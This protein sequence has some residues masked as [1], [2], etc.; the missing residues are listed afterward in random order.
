MSNIFSAKYVP[1]TANAIFTTTDVAGRTIEHS[2]GLIMTLGENVGVTST[3]LAQL[4]EA[5]LAKATE[6]GANAIIGARFESALGSMSL[7]GT[8][9]RL[10][11]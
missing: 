9:V 4:I 10:S 6:L 8:A 5:S 3:S 1:L 7:Y 11:Q 2:F